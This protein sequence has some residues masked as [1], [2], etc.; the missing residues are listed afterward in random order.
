MSTGWPVR[1]DKASFSACEPK[2][3]VLIIDFRAQA[4]VK[5]QSEMKRMERQMICVH[6]RSHM[7]LL[8]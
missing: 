7:S 1:V 3:A 4:V 8:R 6:V 2:P 5:V